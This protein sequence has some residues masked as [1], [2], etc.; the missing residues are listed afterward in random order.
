VSDLA[1]RQAD[2]V[3][4]LVA[5]GPCPDGF[6]PERVRLA[7]EALMRKRARGV[8]GHWPALGALPD[9]QERF[10]RWARGRPPGSGHDEGIAFA[11]AL[12]TALPPAARVEQ[13]LAGHGRVAREAGAFVVRWPLLGVRRLRYVPR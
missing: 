2:L 10:A 6:D 12:G 9:F 1:A 11:A 3:R 8:A 5:D 13:L 4:A 7:G